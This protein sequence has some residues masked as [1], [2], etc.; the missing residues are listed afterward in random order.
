[1]LGRTLAYFIEWIVKKQKNPNFRFDQNISLFM[2]VGLITRQTMSRVR[3]KK[4]IFRGRNFRGLQLGRRVCFSNLKK[5]RLDCG[6]RLGDSVYLD[7]LGLGNLNIGAN[8][9]VGS[10]SRIIVS[11]SYNNLGRHINIGCN[12]AIAEF[13]YLGGA[14]GLDIGDDVIAGQFLSIHPENHIFLTVSEPIRLQGV[15]REGVKIGSNVWIGSK[16][17]ILDGVSIGNDCVIAAGAVLTRGNYA[18]RSIIAG[19][20]AKII[21]KIES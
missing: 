13:S 9:S 11:T 8:S 2:L 6:V 16:V 19:V 10:Y 7:G 5:I 18:S 4:L 20:P 12:V 3:A 21:G 1:M 17:T 15:S 14:G